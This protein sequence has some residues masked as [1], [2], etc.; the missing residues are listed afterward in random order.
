METYSQPIPFGPYRLIAK[1]AEGGM[2]EVF[3]AVST[4]KELEGQFLALKKL[5]SALNENK[6]FV[7]LLIHEAKVGVL[8]S[9]PSIASVFD[10]G[11]H[12]SEF[13]LAMEYVHGKSLDR[14]L[15][16]IES[17]TAPPIPPEV[18]AFITFEVIRAL[19]F[20]HDLKDV[21]GRDLNIIHRDV[22]PGNI[23]LEYKGNVK[24]ADFGIATAE[25]RLQ[26]EFTQSAMGKM[27]YMPP[28]QA[29]NDPVV[30]AS[31][32]YSLGVVYYQMLSGRLPYE[33]D[34]PTGL[35]RKIV[36][37]NP[38]DI[39]QGKAQ[40]P[41]GLA[42]I[43]ARLLDKSPRKR[44]Q[45]AAEL[46]ENLHDFFLEH[47]DLDFDSRAVRNYYRKKLA[48]YLREVFEEEI[49]EELEVIQNTIRHPPEDEELKSTAP[50]EIPADIE[51]PKDADFFEE[52][53][54][55]VVEMDHTDEATRH[56]PL[57]DVEREQ[58]LKGTSPKEAM[59]EKPTEVFQ[60]AT[61]PE[62]DLVDSFKQ[63]TVNKKLDSASLDK[64]Q[65]EELLDKI[66]ALEITNQDLLEEFESSTFSGKRRKNTNF[67]DSQETD[68]EGRH[69]ADTEAMKT[70]KAEPDE[71]VSAVP[72]SDSLYS[73]QPDFHSTSSPDIDLEQAMPRSNPSAMST[74]LHYRQSFLQRR[75]LD[76]TAAVIVGLLL[77]L[78][79]GFYFGYSS[80]KHYFM[81][82]PNLQP[83]EEVVIQFLGESSRDRQ[84]NLFKNITSDEGQG[85]KKVEELYQKEFERYT[86]QRAPLLQLTSL[87]PQYLTN[88][89]STQENLEGLLGSIKVFKFFDAQGF[90]GSEGYDSKLIVYLYDNFSE[91]PQVSDLFFDGYQGYRGESGLVLV[92]T[93]DTNPFALSLKIAQ[94]IARMHGASIKEDPETGL[95]LTPEGLADPLARPL[96]PQKAAEL[97]A[98]DLALGPLHER[99]ISSFD[100]MV[101]G[102]QTAYEFGWIEEQKKNILLGLY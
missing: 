58:I 100:E 3:L 44:P 4:K 48:E 59:Q 83:T 87:E 27:V 10:L 102:P 21:K 60:L 86:N 77:A 64:H 71:E 16:R 5:H 45:N 65:R 49:I 35:Y 15:E 95:A 26:V 81:I 13:F 33:A 47:E 37:G 22:T 79:A 36:E 91:S 2:A 97:M 40:V 93:Y 54:K 73:S 90:Q 61:I 18:S 94:E 53:E 78:G 101:I 51:E 25:S 41:D 43:L 1:V 46:F 6:P 42:K 12:K 30:R 24:L 11:S 82:Y 52:H 69:F 84:F 32:L 96:Y 99:P 55:T 88:P 68:P 29:A 28:E 66:P 75:P 85:L 62:Y 67:D 89:L 57:T 80:M 20:A 74:P 92:S 70:R 17:G 14:V 9:H 38:D 34:S 56:Y 19:A 23:L 7:N 76:W 63:P 72:S 50:Q 39:Q 31:D 98:G 8:L